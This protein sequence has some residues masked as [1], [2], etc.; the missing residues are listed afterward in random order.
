MSAC[1]RAGRRL[2]GRTFSRSTASGEGQ[3]VLADERSFDGD[4][5]AGLHAQD[6][7]RELVVETVLPMPSAKNRGVW[8]SVPPHDALTAC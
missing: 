7:I 2:G 3:D 1:C 6:F 4:L 5:V 8:S